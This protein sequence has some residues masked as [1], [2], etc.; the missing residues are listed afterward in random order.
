VFSENDKIKRDVACFDLKSFQVKIDPNEKRREFDTYKA[1]SYDSVTVPEDKAVDDL[2][3]V[4]RSLEPS[5]PSFK[6]THLDGYPV[7]C[8]KCDGDVMDG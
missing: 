2:V 8:I 5:M 3:G 1:L 4:L 6:P 7:K